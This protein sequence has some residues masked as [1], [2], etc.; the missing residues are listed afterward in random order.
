MQRSS[1]LFR[2]GSPRLTPVGGFFER[3]DWMKFPV[4]KCFQRGKDF[5]GP[6]Q[7]VKFVKQLNK[8]IPSIDRH[9]VAPGLTG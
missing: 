6:G 8:E 3:L 9:Q 4:D 2:Q 7:S 5:L 1:V